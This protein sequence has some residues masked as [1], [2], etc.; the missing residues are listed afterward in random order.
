MSYKISSGD[1]EIIAEFV[2]EDDRDI[3]L[4][5]LSEVFD[6]CKFIAIDD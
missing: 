4:D 6:D 2:Y 3:C 1:N 5:A